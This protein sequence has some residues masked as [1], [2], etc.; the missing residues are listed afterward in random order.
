MNLH[1][2]CDLFNFCGR[3]WSVKFPTKFEKGITYYYHPATAF[4]F[5]DCKQINNY[6]FE[7][8]QLL[9]NEI[10]SL[11]IAKRWKS[12][13]LIHKTFFSITLLNNEKIWTYILTNR[14]PLMT[15]REWYPDT[16]LALNWSFLFR[17]IAFQFGSCI[18][19]FACRIWINLKLNL[20]IKI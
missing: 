6:V 19:A 10:T 18:F 17:P 2:F 12:I 7:T 11:N 14:V 9:W 16:S 4:F 15:L 1:K 3:F 13:V 8:K 5:S 20:L